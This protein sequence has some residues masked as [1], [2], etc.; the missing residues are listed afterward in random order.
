M[1]YTHTVKHNGVLYK[2]GTEVP[3]FSTPKTNTEQTKVENNTQSYTKT[4]INRTPVSELRKIAL[5]TGVENAENMTGTE[6]KEY[7]INVFGL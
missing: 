7:L 5:N 1:K 6:L 3:A 4:E 2:A